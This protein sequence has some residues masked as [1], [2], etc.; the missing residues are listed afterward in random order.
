MT[1]GVS[2]L[3]VWVYNAILLLIPLTLG[4][5]LWQ[6]IAA[7]VGWNSEWRNRRLLRA[8]MFV[9]VA[10]LIPVLL[11]G[12]WRGV[13]RPIFA[14]QM[15]V[16]RNTQRS[17]MLAATSVVQVGDQVPKLSVLTI[18]GETLSLPSQGDVMLINFF[19]TWCGP[20]L[21]E[22]PFLERLWLENKANPKFK[23]LAIGREESE[24]TLEPFR[25]KLKLTFPISPDV[26]QAIFS[27][28][29]K[30]TIPRTLIIAPDGRIVYSKVGFMEEDLPE[31][32]AVLKRELEN[33]EK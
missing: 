8:G 14:S 20:C 18:D 5:A 21:V 1:N 26:D 32:R 9:A 28:F 4:L 2:V 33:A 27:Q 16:E 12:L 22:L 10:L 30:E 19:A 11:T 24:E 17:E 15:M 3:L 25:D 23:L 6:T 29:A 31:L 7:L 13:M